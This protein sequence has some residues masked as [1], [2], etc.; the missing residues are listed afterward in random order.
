[1]NEVNYFT[2]YGSLSISLT[3]FSLIRWYMQPRSIHYTLYTITCLYFGTGEACM[4]EVNAPPNG[5]PALPEKC[6]L[7][8]PF[9]KDRLHY[10]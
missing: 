9:L 4:Y 3:S 10:S 5:R 7:K 8:R 6:F 2:T 1:M